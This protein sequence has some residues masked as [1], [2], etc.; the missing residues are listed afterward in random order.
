LALVLAVGVFSALAWARSQLERPY[1][2]WDAP[3]VVVLLEPGMN[4]DSMLRRLEKAGVLRYPRLAR[5]WLSW[6]G[7]AEKLQ[8]GEYL[9]DRPI[10]PIA[11]LDRLR[12]GDVLLYPVT[13][14]EGLTS[15]EISDRLIEA[16][17]GS[18]EEWRSVFG[19]AELIQDLDPEAE[20]LEG[21]LF[22]DTYRFPIGERPQWIAEVM[23]RRFRDVVG[24][25]YAQRAQEI[26]L[27]LRS[28]VVL[29]SLIEKETS[30][31]LERPR[32][33]RVFHNRLDRGM[34]LECDPTVLYALARAGREV[35]R[36]TYDDLEFESPWNT[37]RVRG[38]P[39][40]PIANPGEASLLAALEPT[41]G[42]D[43]YFV[44]APEGG[45]RFSPTL[46][47]HLEAV[48]AWRRHE[49]SSR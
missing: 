19:S 30:V 21:Y 39:A 43:L 35:E 25:S 9:F 2:G 27:D 47:E 18:A 8:A 13:L 44:A 40:G 36:L 23:V 29:A 34:R 26:G 31:P 1:V 4:A 38:L 6:N 28:A 3:S 15:F 37:Y 41:E 20:D 11:L 22:P 10:S 42:D 46:A 48:A 16:G 33:S 45:H 24:E 5:A 17:F 12:A 7:G 49:R 14:P 32:I